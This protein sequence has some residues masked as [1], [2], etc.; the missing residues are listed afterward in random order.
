MTEIINFALSALEAKGLCS[1]SLCYTYVFLSPLILVFLLRTL[2]K[3]G[4]L[5]KARKKGN[6]DKLTWFQMEKA[7]KD[8]YKSKGFK[9]SLKGGGSA[10]GGVDLIAKKGRRCVLVQVKHYKS[11]VGVKIVREMLGVMVDS[12]QFNELHIISSTGFTKPARELA[13]RHS[14]VLLG[15]KELIS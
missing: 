8:Y 10:D 1:G 11:N 4:D 5:E 6:F 2:M 3:K 15:R 7:A 9:V 13:S 12:D 14:I